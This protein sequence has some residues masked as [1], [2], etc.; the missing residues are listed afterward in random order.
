MVS[1]S[2]PIA[3]LKPA[4]KPPVAAHRPNWKGDADELANWF[5]G[6]ES[7]LGITDQTIIDSLNSVGGINNPGD[8]YSLADS[9]IDNINEAMRKPGVNAQG[10]PIIPRCLPPS[11]IL[12]LK[13]TATLVQY[14]SLTRR[15]ITFDI[16]RWDN[17]ERFWEEW[18]AYVADKDEEFS[19]LTRFKGRSTELPKYLSQTLADHLRVVKGKTTKAPLWYKVQPE[20]ERDT[21]FPD[22]A[23]QVHP[24]CAYGGTCHNLSEGLVSRLSHETAASN[25][26]GAALFDILI[27]GF[28]GTFVLSSKKEYDK[29][30]DGVGW[31]NY[32]IKTYAD[33]D[34]HEQ[35][36][37]DALAYLEI[38]R[39]GGSKD[40]PMS[41]HLEKCRR[42]YETVVTAAEYTPV[43][44]PSERDLVTKA[45][46]DGITSKDA[47]VVA[48]L[49]DITREDGKGD[50][51]RNNW[52][53]AV[54]HMN[55]ADYEGKKKT[56]SKKKRM[57]GTA[58][59]AALGG[60]GPRKKQKGKKGDKPAFKVDGMTRF[61]F[62]MTCKG[63]RGKTGVDLRYYPIEEL[64]KL[65]PDQR[66]EL[67]EWRERK[68]IEKGFPP[69]QRGSRGGSVASAKKEFQSAISSLS[70][71]AS[72]LATTMASVMGKHKNTPSTSDPPVD[73]DFAAAIE[74]LKK[75]QS[76]Q[77]TI[78]SAIGDSKPAAS[79]ASG[80][81]TADADTTRTFTAANGEA[82]TLPER[83]IAAIRKAQMTKDGGSISEQ[84][85]Q[86]AATG[87]GSILKKT[88]YGRKGAVADR[89]SST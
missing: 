24:G 23:P 42:M 67:D 9:D 63:G 57:P 41:A 64:K 58:D 89:A 5:Q 55:T 2:R 75:I 49:A 34:F 43:T 78:S 69:S 6:R 68:A 28:T 80:E 4:F 12:R 79:N 33:A 86:S 46:I 25:A 59:V 13:R 37:K 3:P 17:V 87:L 15:D 31:Y 60:G 61:Q 47:H 74:A 52:A 51:L 30:R 73:A 53:K 65:P 70:T 85:K 77:A 76:G 56:G 82:I 18:T 26:D 16:I 8:L 62:M 22:D 35:E 48:R 81:G 45:I 11:T 7:G 54:A 20:N 1:F 14:L 29:Q 38:K 10:T 21:T 44:V 39:W 40:G 83:A 19:E 32:L 84:E 50:D 66:Q 36:A 71:V 72:S 27:H 88:S